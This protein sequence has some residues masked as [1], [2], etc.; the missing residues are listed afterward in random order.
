MKSAYILMLI[1]FGLI[2]QNFPPSAG[3]PGSTAIHSGSIFISEWVDDVEVIR[4]PMDISQPGLGDAAF[5]SEDDAEGPSNPA[6]V[7]LGDGGEAIIT[8][9]SSISDHAGY[10]FAI[11][12]NSFS[13][14]F[15][16]LAF[17][18]VSSDGE[19]YFRFDAVSNTDTTQQIGPFNTLDATYIHNLAGKYQS[20]YGTPFDL[21]ELSG[22]E[23][24]NINA[25]THIKIID[26][27]GCIQDQYARYDSEGKKI[28]DPW[29]TAFESSGFD[30][31]A[32]ALLLENELTLA[33]EDNDLLYLFEDNVLK[34]YNATDFKHYEIYNLTGQM[35]KRGVLGMEISFHEY[36]SGAYIVR[37]SNEVHKFASLKLFKH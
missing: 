8:L 25:I 23:G 18:E 10:D 37:F 19:N 1:P 11:F 14:D 13:A 22:E 36:S 7:S 32:V 6:V 4:G 5:G 21:S 30:L 29:P 12:E 33:E 20:Q 35:L 9:S 31:D 26:V 17:V 15:L 16:E 27:V 24:L 3:L 2:A 28:N 34:V